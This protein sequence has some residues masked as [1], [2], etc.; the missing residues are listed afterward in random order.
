MYKIGMFSKHGKVTIKTLHHYDE[1]GLLRPAY[2]DQE[3]GYR[4][5]TSEQLS[6]LHEIVALRQIGFSISEILK[7]IAG[8]N[9]DEILK[10]RKT[11]LESEYQNITNK[12]FRLNYYISEKKEGKNM[13]YQVVIKEIPEC[14][15]F[16][17]RQIIKNYGTL[18]HLVPS[19]GKQVMEANPGLKC[20]EPEYCFNIYHDGEYKEKDIDVEVCQAVVEAG[21]E[22]DGI[23][24]KKIPAVTVASV[25]HKGPYKDFGAAY[26]FI[27][28]WIEQNGYIILDNVRESYI[29]GIWNKESE[30]EWLTEIQVPIDQN[31]KS[32]FYDKNHI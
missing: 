14:I 25:M 19:I 32:A 13:N 5:Y 30:D 12:L 26:A 15:V 29:D 1:V 28:K 17:K 3:T 18:M 27:F 2:I 22:S 7:I 21:V 8:S 6:Q 23:I 9:V 20:A 4:Y 10:Q 16:S 11:E 24:F 31:K